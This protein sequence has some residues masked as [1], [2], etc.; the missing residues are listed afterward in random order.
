M[1][2]Q[3]SREGGELEMLY[4]IGHVL[5]A[6][7]FAHVRLAKNRKNDLQVAI[8]FVHKHLSPTDAVR[9]ELKVLGAVGVHP[10]I[11]CLLGCHE[12]ST[13]FALVLELAM[14]GEV[15]ER[16]CEQGAYSERDASRVIGQVC[17]AVQHLHS[18]G[19]CHRDLKPENL[20]LATPAAESDVK[21]TDF[22]LAAFCTAGQR[23]HDFVGTIA[24]A[25][26]ELLQARPD[27][28]REIDMWCVGGLLFT[29]LGGYGPFDPHADATEKVM[30]GR[31][32]RG[33]S[34]R[35]VRWRRRRRRRRQSSSPPW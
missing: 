15:F 29:L 6:G 18:I 35:A 12:T 1:K 8:K 21:V 27:Y 24:Y 17:K 23:M 19:V 13:A 9:N 20:L 32:L 5:G 14:G 4:E 26:P 22:G 30:R 7:G 33:E 11:V 28:G 10:H 25:A 34:S 31:I 2:R 3:R 16:I